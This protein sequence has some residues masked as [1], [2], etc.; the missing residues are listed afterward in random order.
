MN[1]SCHPSKNFINIICFFAIILF[2]SCKEKTFDQPQSRNIKIDTVFNDPLGDPGSSVSICTYQDSILIEYHNKYWQDSK[3]IDFKS[4]YMDSTGQIRFVYFKYNS[5]KNKFRVSYTWEDKWG[6]SIISVDSEF[7]SN[8]ISKFE[9]ALN[10]INPIGYDRIEYIIEKK[11]KYGKQIELVIHDF[12]LSYNFSNESGKF[13]KMATDVP[14]EYVDW[15]SSSKLEF[16][17]AYGNAIDYLFNA[18]TRIDSEY[19]KI[20]KSK[21]NFDL[22]S[23]LENNKY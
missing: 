16:G 7:V 13:Y 4:Q 9:I 15:E 19:I 1:L 2:S 3:R 8:R 14:I 17:R 22:I 18:V 21:H 20:A 10:S 12:N 23:F 6:Q 5:D 11:Y